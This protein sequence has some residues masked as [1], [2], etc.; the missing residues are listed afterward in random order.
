MKHNK[1]LDVKNTRKAVT[2]S[3]YITIQTAHAKLANP[4]LNV[5]AYHLRASEAASERAS[6]VAL[7]IQGKG[8]QGFPQRCFLTVSL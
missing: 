5:G 6:G 7:S 2:T 3:K 1:T 8:D 4:A